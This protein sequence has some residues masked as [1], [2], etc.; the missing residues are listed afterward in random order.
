MQVILL[1]DVKK[2]GKKGEMVEVSDGYARNFLIKQRLAV[3]ATERSREILEKQQQD[4][5]VEEAALKAQAEEIKAQ[6]EKITLEFKVKAG[7]GGRVFGSVSTKQICDE[8]LKK[9][10]IK[11]DKRKFIDT[12]S[13][14]SLGVTYFKVDLYHNQVIGNI[15][16]HV[17]EA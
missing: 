10:N 8:L 6:L 9:H 15:K 3:A 13:A 11:V 14:Q 2:V 17:S 7:E 5:A 16:I 1:S 12:E 4:K